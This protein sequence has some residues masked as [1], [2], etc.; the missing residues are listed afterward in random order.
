[1]TRKTY[2]GKALDVAFDTDTCIHAGECVRGLPK[3]F[4]PKR[5]PWILP[6][7]APADAIRDVVARCPS[8]ALEIVERGADAAAEAVQITATDGGPFVISGSVCVVGPDGN[9]LGEGKKMALSRCGKSSKA[10]F[11]DGAHAR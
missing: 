8:G 5:K 9:V 6:D 3:V 1:M 7:E 11:C 10:P 4:D 2:A